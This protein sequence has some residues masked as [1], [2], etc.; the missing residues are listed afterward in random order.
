MPVKVLTAVASAFRTQRG[1]LVTVFIYL[2]ILAVLRGTLFPGLAEDD[3]EQLFYAQTWALGYKGNQPPL[4]TWLVKLAEQVLGVSVWALFVVKFGA[5]FVF[6]AFSHA[7][8]RHLITD[9]L[10]AGLA[11]LSPVA[12]YYVGWDMV[13]NY[14]NSILLAA[15]QAAT[16]LTLLRLNDR[17]KVM[18]FV[19]LGLAVAVGLL[20]KYNFFLFLL[21]LLAA[22]F[23][24]S[25]LKG[26]LLSPRLLVAALVAALLVAPHAHWVLTDAGGLTALETSAERPWKE[27]ES[28]FLGALYGLGNLAAG[29]VAFLMPLI[30]LLV[31]FFPRAFGPLASRGNAFTRFFAVYFGAYAILVTFTVLAIGATD[32]QNHWLLGLLPLPLYVFARLEAAGGPSRSTAAKW[33]LAVLSALALLVAGTLVIRA[34]TAPAYCRKCNFFMPWHALAEQLRRSGFERGTIVAFDYP[35][36]IAG[37]LRRYFPEARV[38]SGRFSPQYAPPAKAPGGC[39]VI[40]NQAIEPEGNARPRV[41]QYANRLLGTAFTPDKPFAFID[42]PIEGSGGRT[43][44]LGYVLEPYGTGDCR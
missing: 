41:F 5:L 24:H 11:A 1:F 7:A 22:G 4:Y 40:W 36:Q 15:A 14:S 12:L 30:L 39:L 34:K 37:N 31:L 43:V 32:V 9:R 19:W 33:Y 6:Y 16:L 29:G 38:M 42:A 23:A 2:S 18:D 26:R 44:R 20:T 28:W 25:G 8:A 27:A 10:L 3:S 21:P 35:N 13:V 17:N